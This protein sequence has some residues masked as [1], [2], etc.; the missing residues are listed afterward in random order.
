MQ[1][2]CNTDFNLDMAKQ[3][4]KENLVKAFHMVLM[5]NAMSYASLGA[6]FK[7][8]KKFKSETLLNLNP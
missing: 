1:L 6:L 3:G 2:F 7:L 5:V 4:N 8:K